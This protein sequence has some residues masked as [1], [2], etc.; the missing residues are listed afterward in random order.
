MAHRR[1]RR[2]RRHLVRRGLTPS[3]TATSARPR[4]PG[5]AAPHGLPWLLGRHRGEGGG[6]RVVHPTDGRVGGRVPAYRERVSALLERSPHLALLREARGA[7]RAVRGGADDAT[8]VLRMARSIP[9]LRILFLT[10]LGLVPAR[11]GDPGPKPLL[12]EATYLLDGQYELPYHA[13]VA[14]ARAEVAW[15]EGRSDVDDTALAIA[16]DRGASWVVGELLWWPT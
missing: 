16:R 13:P 14:T 15:L 8:A 7:G 11:P 2:L 5:S 4:R 3:P 10:V 6:A 12:D 1:G 9:L